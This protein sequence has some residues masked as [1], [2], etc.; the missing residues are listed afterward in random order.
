MQTDTGGGSVGEAA[1]PSPFARAAFIEE[2][3]KAA[4]LTIIIGIHAIAP[5]VRGF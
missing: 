3:S 1:R 5:S 2:E 4:V